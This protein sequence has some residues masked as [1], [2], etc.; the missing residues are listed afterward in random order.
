MWLTAFVV[1]S[2]GD[3]KKFIFVDSEDLEG[4]VRW[5]ESRQTEDGCF[6]SVG[7]VLHKEM[8]VGVVG[9]DLGIGTVTGFW[10]TDN[11][12]VFLSSKRFISQPRRRM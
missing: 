3:A 2:F 8:K 6:P 10:L 1:R 12:A 11:R 4:S 9:F 5:I 7:R